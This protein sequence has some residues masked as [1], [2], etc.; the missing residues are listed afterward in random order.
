MVQILYYLVLLT[1]GFVLEVDNDDDEG[2]DDTAVEALLV[3]ELE[4]EGEK[5]LAV[6]VLL[7][8]RIGGL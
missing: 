2:D 6:K 4:L 5:L 1:F 3:E 7:S 8:T